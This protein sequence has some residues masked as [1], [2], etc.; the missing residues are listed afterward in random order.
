MSDAP[1]LAYSRQLHAELAALNR[2][3]YSR[4][5]TILTLDGL[6]IG[7]FGAVISSS[8]DDVAKTVAQAATSTSILAVLAITALAC[9]VVSALMAL[10]S[11]HRSGATHTD[12]T[13]VDDTHLWFFA[14]I[15]DVDRDSFLKAA[16]EVD[17]TQEKRIRLLQIATMAPIMRRR[18]DWVNA[19]YAFSALGLIAFVAA[20]LGYLIQFPTS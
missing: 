7:V 6:V 8:P 14:R 16:T 11:R 4:A 12:P 10:H 3:L 19:A 17:D 5:Q 15:A 1:G 2:D 9:S 20:G 13:K 18:A